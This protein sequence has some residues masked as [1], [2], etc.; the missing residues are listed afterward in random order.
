M[1]SA[2]YLL[3]TVS[4]CP[5]LSPVRLLMNALQDYRNGIYGLVN[6]CWSRRKQ[7][8]YRQ[9]RTTSSES[10]GP[11]ISTDD[12]LHL[13]ALHYRSKISR[14]LSRIPKRR[15]DRRQG[16]DVIGIVQP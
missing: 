3:W 5:I 13:P 14:L 8:P 10:S 12:D 9:A 16:V 2:V 15:K 6:M 4:G 1:K 11:T 7:K